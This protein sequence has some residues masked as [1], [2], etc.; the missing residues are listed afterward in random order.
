MVTALF[1]EGV[2]VRVARGLLKGPN[3]GVHFFLCLVGGD[4]ETVFQVTTLCTERGKHLI[5]L[6]RKGEEKCSKSCAEKRE[7]V[8]FRSGVDCLGESSCMCGQ[9]GSR[10]FQS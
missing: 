5:K 8:V 9:K 6:L 4:V 7:E 10:V 1:R 2:A 3:A